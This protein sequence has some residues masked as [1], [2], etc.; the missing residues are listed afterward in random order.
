M[1]E[2]PGTDP[3]GDGEGE[4]AEFQVGKKKLPEPKGDTE[5]WFP[6]LG[7]VE[8]GKFCISPKVRGMLMNALFDHAIISLRRQVRLEKDKKMLQGK[9]IPEKVGRPG[10]IDA[11]DEAIKQEMKEQEAIVRIGQLISDARCE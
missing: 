8:R 4:Y 5:R 6:E 3:V 9:Y 2:N 10:V 1:A 7:T 11:L